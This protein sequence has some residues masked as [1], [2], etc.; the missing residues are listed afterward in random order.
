[1][2]IRR[3]ISSTPCL[4]LVIRVERSLLEI[5]SGSG[6]VVLHTEIDSS[7]DCPVSTE[8]AQ[9]ATPLPSPGPQ[10]QPSA[11]HLNPYYCKPLIHRESA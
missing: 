4:I 8:S 6:T 10:A 1:M 11:P 9:P 3:V 2:R 7:N 5:A